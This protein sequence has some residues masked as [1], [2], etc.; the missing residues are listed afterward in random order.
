MSA[1]VGDRIFVADDGAESR[2]QFGRK[3]GGGGL[4]D[5]HLGLLR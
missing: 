5:I 2:D 3:R 1:V 4:N